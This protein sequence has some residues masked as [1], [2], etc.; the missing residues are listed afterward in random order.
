M[1]LIEST[2]PDGTVTATRIT[3][4]PAGDDPRHP[5]EM[6][7]RDDQTLRA[8]GVQHMIGTV[9]SNGIVVGEDMYLYLEPLDPAAALTLRRT[10]PVVAVEELPPVGSDG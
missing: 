1:H 9:V 4:G 2:G 7:R 8:T 6:L 5:L 10:T 3:A